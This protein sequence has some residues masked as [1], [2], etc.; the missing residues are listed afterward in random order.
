LSDLK[1]SVNVKQGD[2]I[3]LLVGNECDKTFEREVLREE[4]AALA[5]Q[6][7]EI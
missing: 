5:L 7:K 3:F 4:G 2:P 6:Q 1:Y